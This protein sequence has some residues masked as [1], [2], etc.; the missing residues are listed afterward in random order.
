MFL[1]ETVPIVWF[2][3]N[4]VSGC[5]SLL[6]LWRV[7]LLELFSVFIF[8]D[9]SFC[10]FSRTLFFR[11]A[12]GKV[13]G[14]G[15]GT[16]RRFDV[17]VMAFFLDFFWGALYK[18]RWEGSSFVIFLDCLSNFDSFEITSSSSTLES[19]IVSFEAFSDVVLVLLARG[20]ESEVGTD[21]RSDFSSW[22]FFVRVGP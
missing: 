22:F 5:L 8:L 9:E 19:L 7:F 12:C 18:G 3:I 16:K 4:I 2:S 1:L 6:R 21:E 15:I 11:W 17:A 10:L 20:Q 13:V 14:I